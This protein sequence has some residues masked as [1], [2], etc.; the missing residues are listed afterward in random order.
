MSMPIIAGAG[1]LKG[2]EI[3]LSPDKGVL[4]VGFAA[5]AISGLFAISLLLRYVQNHRY[6]PFVLYRWILGALV[7]LNLS[8]FQ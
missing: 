8:H 1:M 3:F 5:A 7:L 6:T 2:K 4:W